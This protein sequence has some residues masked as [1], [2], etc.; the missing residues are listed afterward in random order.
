MKKV[1]FLIGALMA[2]VSQVNAQSLGYRWT[3]AIGGTTGDYGYQVVADNNGYTY[4]LGAF[5]GTVDLDPS[6]STAGFTSQGNYDV[7]LAKYSPSGDYMWGKTFGGTSGDFG[8]GLVISGNAVFVTGTFRNTVDFDPGAGTANLTGSSG[9]DDD[10]F[11]ARYDTA[12]NYVWAKKIGAG[13]AD[14]SRAIAIDGSSNIYITGEF[15]GTVDFDPSGT[16]ANLSATASY[17]VFVA[18]Y[19]SSGNY[20]WAQKVS[21]TWNDF[22]YGITVDGSANVY[23]TGQ[24]NGTAYFGSQ[25]ITSPGAD[26]AFLA[27]YNSSGTALWAKNVASSGLGSAQGKS[28]K[29]DGSGNVYLTGTF[30]GTFDFDPGSGNA[31]LASTIQEDVFLAKYDG[32][33]NY[34][35]AGKMGGSMQDVS[36]SMV[37]DASGNAYVTGY[38]NSTADFDMSAGTTNLTSAGGADIFLVKYN[39]GGTFQWVKQIGSTGNDRGLGLYLTTGTVKSIVLTGFFEGT[40]DFDPSSATDN[41]T[42]S[43]MTDGFV[44]TYCGNAPA[45]PATI[46]GS[47]TVCKGSSN[48][49][50]VTNDSLA[51]NYNWTLPA[52]WSGNSS[53]NSITITAG[54]AGGTISVVAGNT[55]GS[56]DAST[57]S[58]TVN[59]ANTAVVQTGLTLTA[60]AT[61][62]TYQWLNCNSGKAPVSGATLQSYTATSGSYA[63]AVTQNGCTDTSSCFMVPAAG[64]GTVATDWFSVFPNPSKG[65]VMI[66]LQKNAEE[67]KVMVHDA[68]GREILAQQYMNTHEV[69]V[70]LDVPEGIY[71]VTVMEKGGNAATRK[72]VV[73]R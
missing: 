50:L 60:S 42:A 37:L 12:G 9:G 65:T 16:T 34:L 70:D 31:A 7:Y 71:F 8:N 47:S 29:V 4:V 48:V 38:F 11:I 20:V 22:S 23:I 61:G 2:V 56:S 21:T 30:I 36:T 3:K 35:W 18:K 66:N 40:A 26:N 67:I 51:G 6:S 5:E 39:S 41:L 54:N 19:N 14:Y 43:G 58:V 69:W 63:V 25:T 13:I 33:G 55:C 27:K 15:A 28:V 62:A 49:Y 10:I 52:G 24:F 72:L 64:V 46:N 45:K 73:G 44:A 17:D 68:L 53:S 32:S 1:I 57:L 59:T